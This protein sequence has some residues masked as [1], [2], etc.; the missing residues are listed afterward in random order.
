MSESVCTGCDMLSR[1]CLCIKRDIE[2]EYERLIA[3]F[4]RLFDFGPGYVCKP[5]YEDDA[6]SY[7]VSVFVNTTWENYR[8][9]LFSLEGQFGDGT[10]FGIEFTEDDWQTLVAM[11]DAKRKERA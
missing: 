2:Q 6:D 10:T 11:V 5:P 9:T 7:E 8:P 3:A 1:F 4:P